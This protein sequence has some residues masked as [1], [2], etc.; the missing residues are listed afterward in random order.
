MRR[1]SRCLPALLASILAGASG[2]LLNQIGSQALVAAIHSG[3]RGRSLLD[4]S[5]TEKVLERVR[6]MG[7]NTAAFER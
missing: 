6:S 1:L 7:P 4:P 5:V 3:A 2:Y